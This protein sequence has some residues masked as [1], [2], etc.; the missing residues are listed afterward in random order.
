M[1][2]HAS[3]LTC[4]YKTGHSRQVFIRIYPINFMN[5]YLIYPITTYLRQWH[6]KA[7]LTFCSKTGLFVIIII[8]KIQREELT[9]SYMQ[10]LCENYNCL[11][12]VFK[13]SLIGK[14]L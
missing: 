10:M 13:F 14:K 7:G 5:R 9:S 6:L 2:Y 12:A 1:K 4:V 11:K 8:L 3:I